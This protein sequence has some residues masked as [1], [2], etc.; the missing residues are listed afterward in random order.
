VNGKKVNIPSLLVKVGDVVSIKESSLDSVKIKGILEG[1]ASHNAP[2]WLEVD[3]N[4]Q[5]GKVKSL[6]VREQ[7]DIPVEEHLIVELYSR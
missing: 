6:P 2:E 5:S 7:I 1:A 3:L 4:K